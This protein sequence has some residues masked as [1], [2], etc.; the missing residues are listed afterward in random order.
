[1]K[2]TYILILAIIL[3]ACGEDN[4]D[5]VESCAQSN[6]VGTYTGTLNCDGDFTLDEGVDVTITADGSDAIVICYASP[7]TKNCY[8]AITPEGCDINNDNT[9]SGGGVTVTINASLDG[10]NLT[11]SEVV[12][13]EVGSGVPSYTC[14]ITATRN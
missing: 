5:N 14:T 1:M 10:D 7:S 11:I 2:L 13:A 8:L 6:W 3:A 12:D 4:D 9:Q